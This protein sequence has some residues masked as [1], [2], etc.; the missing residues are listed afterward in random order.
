VI[1]S[2][3]TKCASKPSK[4]LFQAIPDWCDLEQNWLRSPKYYDIKKYKNS[5]QKIAKN[6][7][8]KHIKFT[9]KTKVTVIL[10]LEEKGH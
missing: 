4:Q 2:H 1:R 5:L 3:K 10:A 8:E 6:K 7:N 9:K